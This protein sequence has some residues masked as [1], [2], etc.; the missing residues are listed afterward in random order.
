MCLNSVQGLSLQRCP[1]RCPSRWGLRTTPG[2]PSAPPGCP[3]VSTSQLGASDCLCESVLGHFRPIR[4]FATAW[5][6]A[7]QALLSMGF[8]RQECWSGLP[9][10]PPGDLPDPGIK[11]ASYVSCISARATWDTCTHLSISPSPSHYPTENCQMVH[12]PLT[13]WESRRRWSRV[14]PCASVPPVWRTHHPVPSSSLQTRA[15]LAVP[16]NVQA[17]RIPPHHTAPWASW[18]P[19]P[20]LSLPPKDFQSPQSFL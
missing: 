7:R 6:A 14:R 15:K 20:S 11:P 8:S 19:Q 4:L 2:P 1:V 3:A 9:C 17:V 16:E 10:P 13:T 5:T 12:F 18:F